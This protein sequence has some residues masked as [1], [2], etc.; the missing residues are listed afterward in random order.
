MM[1][2]KVDKNGD[3]VDYPLIW[4]NVVY[5]LEKS[6]FTDE[7]LKEHNLAVILNYAHPMNNKPGENFSRGVIVK[8]EDGDIE[9]IWDITKKTVAEKVREWVLGPRH[10]RLMTSDWTQTKDAPL[11]SEQVEKWAVYR[12]QLRDITDTYDFETIESA[13]EI[14]WP[15]PPDAESSVTKWGETLP[16]FVPPSDT[17]PE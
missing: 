15:T 1:Y 3:P 8:N 2:I 6:D 5:L 11:T 10:T 14:E 13:A 16:G 9:Q 17:T 7:D 12:Q 4:E